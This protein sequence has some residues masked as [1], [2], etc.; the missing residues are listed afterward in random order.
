MN[1]LEAIRRIVPRLGTAAVIS[2]LGRNTYDLYAAAK[3]RPENFYMWGAMGS[4]ASVGF[5]LAL[6]QP[7]RRIV[8]L[9]GEGSLLM[10]LGCLAT[11]SVHRPPNLVL[12][13]F[14]NAAYETTGGQPTHTARGVS[15]E[16]IARGAGIEGAVTVEDVD[17]FAR[18][19]ERGLR[20]PGPWVIVAKVEQARDFVRVP[21][22]PIHVKDQFMH[23]LGTT[24]L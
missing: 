6:A 24:D 11:I 14:D 3:E 1:R 7:E 10:N 15:I 13:V 19:V 16:A 8:V 20:E 21:R 12:V 5:G 2:N 4:T 23:A 9:D 22:R 17:A 18:A